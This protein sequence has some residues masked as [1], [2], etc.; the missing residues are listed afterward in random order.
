[1]EECINFIR[2]V[3]LLSVTELSRQLHGPVEDGP[4]GSLE[5]SLT[6]SLHCVTSQKSEGFIYTA[7]EGLNRTSLNAR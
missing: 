3:D 6:L 2:N 4:R 1:V 5:T 7:K